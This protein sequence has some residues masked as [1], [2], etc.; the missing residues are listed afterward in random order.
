[1]S[2]MNSAPGEF[3]LCFKGYKRCH[4]RLN[5]ADQSIKGWHMNLEILRSKAAKL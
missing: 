5:G 2:P 4:M 1:M 3:G